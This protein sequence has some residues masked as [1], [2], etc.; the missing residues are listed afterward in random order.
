[1]SGPGEVAEV[2]PAV[3][4]VVPAV[5]SDPAVVP[6]AVE[7]AAVAPAVAP[8]GDTPPK[9][10]L[11]RIDRLTADKK[12]A[13]RE[14][15]EL[16]AKAGTGGT[17]AGQ[18]PPLTAAI[19]PV[20]VAPVFDA[21]EIDRRA[22]QLA[23]ER[24]EQERIQSQVANIANEGAKAH[25]NDWV[26]TIQNLDRVQ[27]LSPD[28]ISIAHE[29]GNGHE[30]IYALGK[31]MN[32]AVRIAALPPAQKGAALAKFAMKLGA[33]APAKISGAPEPIPEGVGGS[34]PNV[35]LKDEDSPDEW[36]RKRNAERAK[37]RA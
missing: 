20:P 31:D 7:P 28:M 25:P 14:I 35:G 12:A 2:V 22:Q 8:V 3:A 15:E 26:A 27:A 5:V 19:A 23:N 37:R 10:A 33:S 16:K 4:A 6:A 11:E 1:M 32:E 36:F 13:L 9:W 30:I 17:P 24:V 29:L 21:G 34:A 18:V